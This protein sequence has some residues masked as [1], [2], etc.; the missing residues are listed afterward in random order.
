M[1]R[2]HV[3][4]VIILERAELNAGDYAYPEPL[5]RLA[6]RWN[7]SDRIMVSKCKCFQTAASGGFDYCLWCES[8]V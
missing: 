2:Q 3:N 7:S 8:P 4:F 5:A 1:E 6:R